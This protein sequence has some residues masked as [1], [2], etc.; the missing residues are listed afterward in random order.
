MYRI[1]MDTDTG[2][3]INIDVRLRFWGLG[4][5]AVRSGIRN[6]NLV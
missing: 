3:D 2:A 6:C 5:R 1:S 4:F